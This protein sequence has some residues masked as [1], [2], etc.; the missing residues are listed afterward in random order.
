[1]SLLFGKI[2][3]WGFLSN[4]LGA[5]RLLKMTVFQGKV[6]Q[7]KVK[8]SIFKKKQKTLLDTFVEKK[9]TF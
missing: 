8:C 9:D 2:Q 4:P 3:I 5:Q 7:K 6:K 1:M